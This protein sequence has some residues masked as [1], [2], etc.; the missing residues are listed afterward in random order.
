M[1]IPDGAQP[2]IVLEYTFEGLLARQRLS[3]LAEPWS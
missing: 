1:G 3:Y 2:S